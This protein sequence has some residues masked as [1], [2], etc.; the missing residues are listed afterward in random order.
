MSHS[1]VDLSSRNCCVPT[2]LGSSG[3]LPRPPGRGPSRLVLSTS[4][5]WETERPD[6]ASPAPVRAFQ[7]SSMRPEERNEKLGPVGRKISLERRLGHGGHLRLRM[8]GEPGPVVGTNSGKA[9]PRGPQ[10]FSCLGCISGSH[11]WCRRAAF[12]LSA[13]RHPT[14]RDGIMPV[15]TPWCLPLLPRAPTG[16]SSLPGVS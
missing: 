6:F 15:L 5:L 2:C 3:M 14:H 12:V 11:S 1:P 13:S 10:P 4:S 8:L 9:R 16:R 7:S